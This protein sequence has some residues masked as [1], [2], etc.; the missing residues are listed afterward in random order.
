MGDELM[1]MLPHRDKDKILTLYSHY[2]QYADLM[3]ENYNNTKI[4][5]NKKGK[6]SSK[7]KIEK[8][9]YLLSW[10]SFLAVTCEGFKKLKVRI[11]LLCERPKEFQNICQ[12]SD[13]LNKTINVHYDELRKLRNSVFHLRDSTKAIKEFLTDEERLGWALLLHKRF[14]LFFKEYWMLCEA[15]YFTSNRLEESIIRIQNLEK[16]RQTKKEKKGPSPLFPQT[17]PT[18]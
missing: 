10:L 8:N 13:Y 17:P 6:M 14:E 18:E 3:L 5:I 12:N 1:K 2:F 7:D 15:E 9:I 11:I 16:R 4:K